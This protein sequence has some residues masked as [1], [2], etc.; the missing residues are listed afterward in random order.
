MPQPDAAEADGTTTPPMTGRSVLITGASSGIGA[1]TALAM[2]A[3]GVK[4]WITYASDRD[5]AER[6]AA[7]CAQRGAHV[8]VSR[9]DQGVPSSIRSLFDEVAAQWSELH[10][11]VNNGGI[12]PH[13]PWEQITIDEWD[14]V[15]E[16]N[17]RGP[18]LTTS[19]AVPLLRAAAGDRAIVNVSSLAA[20]VGGITTSVHYAA[21]KAAVL[22]MTRSFARLPAPDGIRVNAVSPGP[23][24]TKMTAPLPA[25]TRDTL[26]GSVPLKRLAQPAEIAGA[27]ALLASPTS[28][29]TTG[30]TYD[31]NG[32]LLMD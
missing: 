24:A 12:C 25:G 16:A 4:L 6:T 28:G 1:A 31:V 9:L 3:D 23:V 11:L 26:A 14:R 30:A 15:M 5:G 8:R 10:V 20:Q 22:A 17:A 2:A 32:G 13:T 21:S 27:I 7:G 29:F 18:F 19:A